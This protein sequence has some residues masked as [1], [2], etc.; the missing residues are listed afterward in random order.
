MAQW[1]LT[2]RLALLGAAASGPALAAPPS[3]VNVGYIPAARPVLVAKARR[4]FGQEARA[5]LNWLPLADGA[6][7]NAAIADGRCDVALGASSVAVAA[8]LSDGLPYTVVA[9]L[10]VGPD[11]GTP[12]PVR[13][14]LEAAGVPV[15]HLM[16]VR[17]AFGRAYPGAVAGFLRA[18]DR[19]LT[20]WLRRPQEAA[21]VVAAETGVSP[22][23]ALAEM[24]RHQFLPLRA[25]QGPRWLGVTGRAGDL[26]QVLA[27][28][29][30]VLVGQRVLLS[31]P[32][33]RA[34]E[35]A[36]DTEYLRRAIRS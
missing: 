31:A 21:E 6:A 14:A 26:T 1:R 3:G 5:K 23:D 28:T 27:S 13:A 18:Y 17:N 20:T 16:M 4:W 24:R 9:I 29:A 34:F 32:D 22:A 7:L 36:I 15:V 19:A 30:E 2:R 12:A 8:G 33:R 25:Q 10:D 11:S 35:R